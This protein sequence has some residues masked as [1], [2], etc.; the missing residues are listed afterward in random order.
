MCNLYSL[1]KGQAAIRACFR[2]SN[3]RT[4]NL[5][6]FPSIFP[7]ELAPIVRNG[8]DGKPLR[9]FAIATQCRSDLPL[10]ATPP[11]FSPSRRMSFK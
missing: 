9:Q 8:A 11:T 2:A 5:P 6:L 4:G 3:D 1:T 10:K 7:D